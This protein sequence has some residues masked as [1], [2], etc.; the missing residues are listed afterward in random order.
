MS[1][2]DPTAQTTGSP[3]FCHLT[4]APAHTSPPSQWIRYL[5][6]VL[7]VPP[8]CCHQHQ[9]IKRDLWTPSLAPPAGHAAQ[10]QPRERGSRLRHAAAGSAGSEAMSPISR[11]MLGA[12]ACITA[13]HTPA[14][15]RALGLTAG[16][17]HL[18]GKSGPAG[19]DAGPG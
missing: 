6:Q 19:P 18:T 14:N 10:S 12:R 9:R 4:P 17:S 8:R 13:P 3:Q 15:C 16:P 1:V 11:R 7:Q 5:I 2:T